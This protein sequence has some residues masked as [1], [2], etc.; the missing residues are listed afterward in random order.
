MEIIAYT[1]QI[2]SKTK[3]PYSFRDDLELFEKFYHRCKT[4]MGVHLFKKS[5]TLLKQFDKVKSISLGKYLGIIS[6]GEKN[7]STWG[8]ILVSDIESYKVETGK[9]VLWFLGGTGFAIK[10]PEQLIYIDP[11]LGG[12]LPEFG[13]IRMIPIPMDPSMIKEANAVLCTHEH[14]DHCNKESLFPI[15]SN[16]N[17]QFIAPKTA[18]KKMQGWGFKKVRIEELVPGDEIKIKDLD[19]HATESYDPLSKGAVTYIIRVGKTTVFHSGDSWYFDGYLKIGKKWNIDIA[20]IDFGK[21][22]LGKQIYMT[23][24]DFFRTANDLNTSIA[25]PIHWDIW[26]HSYQDPVILNELSRYLDFN[27]K[28]LIMRQGDRLVYP[29]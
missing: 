17:A 9:I 10:T 19:I 28:I 26:K 2:T 6:T 27:S 29:P 16:T 15:Y 20:L 22:P 21:N 14:E 11:Y 3:N 24:C 18:V 4:V 1:K 13:A 7:L 5:K 23:S 25:V 12:S 8:D